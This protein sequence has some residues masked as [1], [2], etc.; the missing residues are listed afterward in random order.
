MTLKFMF[1]LPKL[2]R[3]QKNPN[4][5]LYTKSF[6]ILTIVCSQSYNLLQNFHK[7]VLIFIYITMW[8]LNWLG[9]SQQRFSRFRFRS[10]RLGLHLETVRRNVC[11]K[12]QDWRS[13]ANEQTVGRKLL[14]PENKEVGQAKGSRQ[15]E[16]FLHVHFGPYLQ[17]F[18][19]HHE[20]QVSL[21]TF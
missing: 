18:R 16:V 9:R 19:H 13:E 8:F 4:G 2:A 7:Y 1:M 15:Q 20:L 21:Q 3:K 11:R 17:D 5:S 10:A 6:A 12:I 14:Q